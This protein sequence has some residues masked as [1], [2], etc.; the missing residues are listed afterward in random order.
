MFTLNILSASLIMLIV[1]GIA[2]YF[3]SEKVYKTLPIIATLALI[4]FHLNNI[5]L[6]YAQRDIKSN[7]EKLSINKDVLELL[8]EKNKKVKPYRY[9][10]IC[11]Y[12]FYCGDITKSDNSYIKKIKA[13]YKPKYNIFWDENKDIFPKD[14]ICFVENNIIR[15]LQ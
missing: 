12:Y 7:D 13:F 10:A 1:F 8:N 6:Q 4:L 3:N 15:T 9:F 2:F 5:S 11:E 14:V